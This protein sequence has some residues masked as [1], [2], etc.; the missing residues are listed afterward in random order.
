MRAVSSDR[1]SELLSRSGF[2]PHWKDRLLRPL[3]SIL[4]PATRLSRS[5]DADLGARDAG[6][7]MWQCSP[8]WFCAASRLWDF[9][10]NIPRRESGIAAEPAGAERA[11]RADN[12]YLIQD[13]PRR[14]GLRRQRSI[15]TAALIASGAVRL[16][17]RAEQTAQLDVVAEPLSSR[18][19]APG[20][21]A[22]A[23]A[24]AIGATTSPAT[25]IFT[26]RRPD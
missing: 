15:A 13:A 26:T 25:A 17:V 14:N 1:S 12:L 16:A 6:P 4:L 3:L 19:P 22:R 21:D 7:Q 5:A 20:P 9:G 2:R 11:T 10:R 18:W 24:S 8:P 23:A